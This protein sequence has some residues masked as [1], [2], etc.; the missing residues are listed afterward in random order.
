KSKVTQIN[1]DWERHLLRR[2]ELNLAPLDENIEAIFLQLNPSIS[3]QVD[4]NLQN[5]DIEIISQED[6]GFIIGASLDNLR[7][8]KEKINGFTKTE[9]GSGIIAELWEI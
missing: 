7:T 9:H 1:E 5:L 8:L 6:E 2:N 4:F 3:E